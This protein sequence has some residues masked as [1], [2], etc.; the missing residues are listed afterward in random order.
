MLFN[1]LKKSGSSINSSHDLLQQISYGNLSI[2]GVSIT[3]ETAMRYAPV[4]AC[5]KV[6][7]ETVG[8]L[9]FFLYEKKGNNKLHAQ[10]H[11]LYPLLKVAPNDF[12]TS[13]EW[14]EMIVAHLCL[15]GNQYNWINRVG[16]KVV[17]YIPLNTDSVSVRQESDYTLKYDV[18]FKD[19]S[20]KTFDA[21]D[22]LHFKIG[23]LDGITGRSIISQGRDSIGLGVAAQKY[24]SKLFTNGGRPSGLLSTEADLGPEK[25][26]IL[27]EEWEKTQGGENVSSTAVLWGGLKYDQIALSAGDAQFL[28]TRK[29]QRSEIAGMFR[30][31]PHLIGDLDKAT[32]SNIE[33]QWLSF[34]NAGLESW[35]RRIESGI[36]HKLLKKSEQAKY[37]SQLKRNALLRGD[38]KARSE[39]YGKLFNI[40]VLNA[41]EIRRLED[42]NERSDEGGEE[43]YVQLNMSNGDDD[44]TD[45]GKS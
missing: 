12:Q 21:K 31:P 34:L 28:E 44:K 7:Q 25:A 2:A 16:E 33:H 43:Y 42:M 30:V 3:P 6:L 8:Q 15:R 1:A 41:N 19:G 40:G 23:S 26:K 39:F 20:S 18:R 5:I 22:I 24:G 14:R 45:E 27:S 29:F 13:Q 38:T 17:E 37:Y 10:D 36:D 32:F 11:P 35:F 9:P 4:Y